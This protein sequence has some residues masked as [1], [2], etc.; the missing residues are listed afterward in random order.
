MT[1]CRKHNLTLCKRQA[2]HLWSESGR[3][4]NIIKTL[5][6]T[7][8]QPAHIAASLLTCS[9]TACSRIAIEGK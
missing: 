2:A 8:Y 7:D 3:T 6:P 1:P 4:R 9:K 5:Q